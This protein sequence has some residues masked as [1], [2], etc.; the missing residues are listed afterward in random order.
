M[1]LYVVRKALILMAFMASQVY[2]S[3]IMQITDDEIIKRAEYVLKGEVSSIYTAIE[4]TNMPF[5][6]ITIDVS[7]IYKNNP[8]RPLYISD[9]IVIRQMGG[10]AENITLSV[11]SLPKFV[12]GSQVVVS[13]KHDK[14]GFYYVVGNSQ[15]LYKV[16]NDKLIKDTQN[17][18]T[19]FVRYGVQGEIKFEPGKVEEIDIQQIKTKIEAVE[20]QEN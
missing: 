14:N 4:K 20:S 10:T 15:G 1:K 19:M 13:L 17:T 9:K 16:V 2:A 12:E 18:G 8:D 6:Y 7:E 3:T 11:D 5:Q